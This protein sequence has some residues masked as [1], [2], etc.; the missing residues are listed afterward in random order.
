MY[1]VRIWYKL[2]SCYKSRRVQT[3]PNLL[4][5]A[6]LL[7]PEQQ[8]YNCK[9]LI[10]QMGLSVYIYLALALLRVIYMV[11][12]VTATITRTLFETIED[13]ATAV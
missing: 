10:Q 7:F 5:H 13:E 12:N 3:S 4:Q 9:L 6:V 11:S 8:S 1:Y 2:T